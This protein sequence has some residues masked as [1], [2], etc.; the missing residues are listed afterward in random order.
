ME[1]HQVEVLVPD[2]KLECFCLSEE[3]FYYQDR[4]TFHSEPPSADD[5]TFGP[6]EGK[7]C[8]FGNQISNQTQSYLEEYQLALKVHKKA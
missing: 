4:L 3:Y 8:N 1:R 7:L 2:E 5:S 6:I